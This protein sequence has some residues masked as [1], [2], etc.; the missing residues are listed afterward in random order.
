MHQLPYVKLP[1][2]N[3]VVTQRLFL[4][5]EEVLNTPMGESLH[6]EDYDGV[7][8]TPTHLEDVNKTCPVKQEP[9]E[10]AATLGMEGEGKTFEAFDS[11]PLLPV[12]LE[13]QRRDGSLCVIEVPDEI[14]PTPTGGG[15]RSED[16][17]RVTC[18]QLD[19]EVHNNSCFVKQEPVDMAG[20]SSDCGGSN[21]LSSSKERSD[22]ECLDK[23]VNPRDG[24]V[25]G[26]WSSISTS[27]IIVIEGTQTEEGS[28]RH[29][30]TTSER[31]HTD[32]RPFKCFACPKAFKTKSCLTKHKISHSDEKPFKCPICPRAF[33]IKSY[34]TVHKISHSHERPFKCPSCPK[35]F[36]I[37]RSLIVHKLSHSD[38]R[39]FKCPSCPKAFK[40]KSLLTKHKLSHSDERPF[41]CPSCPKAFKMKSNLTV[42]K[43]SHSHERPFKCPSCPKAFKIKSSLIVHKLAHS[44]ERPFKCPSC[45]KAF[46]INSSLTKH[47]LAHSDERPFKCPSCPKAF[48]INSSLTKHKLS[49][50]DERPFKCPSC[51]KAFTIKS[52]LT[53]HKRSHSDKK[54]FKCPLCA[55]LYRSRASLSVHKSLHH[56]DEK[57]FKYGTLEGA[58]AKKQ[59]LTHHELIHAGP[60][61][62]MCSTSSEEFRFRS[63]MNAHEPIHVPVA[64][65]CP[66]CPKL[67]RA[68]CY[69]DV[70]EKLHKNETTCLRD[71]CQK[72]HISSHKTVNEYKETSRSDTCDKVFEQE[73]GPSRV[74]AMHKDERLLKRGTCLKEFKV[75]SSS[76]ESHLTA[77]GK[78]HQN[79]L[80]Y[81]PGTHAIAV[82]DQEHLNAHQAVHKSESLSKC[83]IQPRAFKLN[84]PL[85]SKLFFQMKLP[86]NLLSNYKGTI[87]KCSTCTMAFTDEQHLNAHQAVHTG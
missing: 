58:F 2:G 42:H 27:K 34:L 61:R 71:I 28:E 87:Y 66:T 50:S 40:T 20:E 22:Q 80:T 65:K 38:E 6:W 1:S 10:F 19:L 37:R 83:P 30:L 68:K 49:H 35:A 17:N 8:T 78:I 32:E 14:L 67:F 47:K 9:E 36:K 59:L 11:M 24:C 79:E 41:K 51:P 52:R 85:Q 4:E 75:K 43:I 46:K 44:D 16:C 82:T 70:H 21:S 23:Q 5:P 57:T 31:V 15:F 48:K 29:C 53:E 64:F 25:F 62:F 54:W 18:P 33:K 45:P 63:K 56:R 39:P 72:S 84:F 26:T 74:Q 12:L 81:R 3:Q 77:R 86:L 13:G 60:R 69:L 73:A 76:S 7:S 55:N